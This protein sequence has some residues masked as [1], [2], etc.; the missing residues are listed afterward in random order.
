MKLPRHEN[1]SG[2]PNPVIGP[3]FTGT[4]IDYRVLLKY[5]SPLKEPLEGPSEEPGSKNSRFWFRV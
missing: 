2:A 5:G 3:P 4:I 1:L